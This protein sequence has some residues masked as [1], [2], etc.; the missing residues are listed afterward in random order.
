[1]RRLG[2]ALF[3]VA[4]PALAQ[5]RPPPPTEQQT[6]IA[7]AESERT[8]AA[9]KEST[10]DR[11]GAE[12]NYARAIELY[13]K[14]LAADPKSADA[15]KAAAGLGAACVAKRDYARAVK[16]LQPYYAQHSDQND[17]GFA[18]GVSLLKLNRTSEAVPILEA[19][20]RANAAEHFMVHYYLGANALQSSDG[21]RALEAFGQYLK[22]RPAELAAGD[23][24]IEELSGR[25]YLLLRRPQEARAAFD[26]SNKLRPSVLAQLGIA[27]ALDMEGRGAEALALVEELGRRDPKN[28]EIAERLTRMYLARSNLGRAAEAATL[29]VQLQRGAPSLILL[30]EVRAA[31]SDWKA[32]E[33]QF[34]EACKLQPKA[35][36]PLL[37]LVKAL[38][39]QGRQDDALAELDRAASDADPAILTELGTANRRAGRFQKAIEAHQRLQKLAPRTVKPYLLLG[40]DHF[41]TGQWDEAVADYSTVLELDAGN[42]KGKKWLSQALV[43]RAHARATAGKASELLVQDLKRALELDPQESTVQ[44]L[45]AVLLGQQKPR[46][47]QAALVERAAFPN[48]AWQTQVL[49]AYALLGDQ[50]AKEAAAI[51]ERV[52]PQIKD[53][54]AL[55]AVEHGWAIAKLKL[56]DYEPAARRLAANKALSTEAQGTLQ[57]LVLR[58]AWKKIEQ[59]DEAGATHELAALPAPAKGSPPA[60][61]AE[62]IRAMVA[63]ENKNFAAAATGIRNALADKQPWFEPAARPLLEAY[64]NYRMGKA[65]EARK[66]LAAALKLAGTGKLPFAQKLTRAMDERE[67]EQLYS[68]NVATALP[69][70]E[71]LLKGAVEDANDPRVVNNLACARYRK[72]GQA[73]SVAAW[74]SISGK[75]PEAD[76]NLGLHA[77]Q[78]DHDPKSAIG[79]FRRY[80]ASGAARAQ[81]ARD[82]ADRLSL[83]F[84]DGGEGE[85]K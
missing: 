68:Q 22:R 45:G 5:Y 83:L 59:G 40:A 69:R 66:Q 34:R 23:S 70:I 30:G 28:P 58:L 14:A 80:A 25:A 2:L 32:A 61:I 78:Q 7:D 50:K 20:A 43:R 48:A 51:F 38:Q 81:Q 84:S 46:E 62:L 12:T 41:A 6:L 57:L 21:A 24:Q 35:A 37:A 67:A 64:V 17:V 55:A 49:Y 11:K 53:V 47:A 1:M 52:L 82:W 60:R 44:L 4:S 85:G 75:L 73:Q 65:A 15:A 8:D 79:H 56:E 54:A 33:Q 77:L 42:D 18:L 13:E 16:T 10:G 26:R 19:L 39:K 3:L 29:L 76:Y 31:Q 36:A 72:G 27:A 9:K 74:K 71:K 63:V